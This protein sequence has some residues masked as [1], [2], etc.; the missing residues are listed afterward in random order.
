MQLGVSQV[1]IREALQQLQAEGF[2]VTES[3]IGPRVA[4]IHAHLIWEIFQLLEALELI[5][6][7]KACARMQTPQ[8]DVM[9]TLLHSLD[10]LDE[11]SCQWSQKNT[12]LHLALCDWGQTALVKSVMSTVLSQ[13]DRLRNHYLK[14]ML[15]PKKVAAE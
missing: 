8:F 11:N 10:D 7:R 3:H 12:R 15:K 6:S 2:V 13:W 1:P 4:E 9:E 5:S 14:D